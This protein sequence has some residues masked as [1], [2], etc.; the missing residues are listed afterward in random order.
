MRLQRLGFKLGMELAAEEKRMAGQL[1]DLDIRRIGRRAGQSQAGAGQQRLVLAVAPKPQNPKTPKP[2]YSDNSS[3]IV[4]FI[5]LSLIIG[6]LSSNILTATV[7]Y[8]ELII[9]AQ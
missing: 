3:L 6:L 8:S 2:L 1:D 5:L 4:F 7:I 9:G